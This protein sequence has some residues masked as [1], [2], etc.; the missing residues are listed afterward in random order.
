MAEDPEHADSPLDAEDQEVGAAAADD[1]DAFLSIV[2]HFYRGEVSQAIS[3]QDRIDRTTNWA[4]T[5]IVALLSVVFSSR[6]LPAYLLLIGLV[7][8]GIFLS[9]EARRYRFFD[10][11]RSRVRLLQ[12]NVFSN[13][14]DPSGV[15]RRHWR[16]ELGDDLQTPTY[17]VTVYEAISRRLSRIYGLLFAI[18]GIAWIAK[19]TLFTPETEWVEA[20]GLPGVSGFVVAGILGAVYLGLVALM[21]WPHERQAKGEI[22]GQEPGRWKNK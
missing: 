12:Q 5:T 14:L 3:A 11:Y 22:H 21:V 9:Y 16:E 15:D 17:K 20:A 13:V 2:P 19:V 10:L 7:A 1:T 8:L 18:L 6:A 4:I